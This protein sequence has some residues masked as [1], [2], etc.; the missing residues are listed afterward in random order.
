MSSHTEKYKGNIVQKLL[1][2]GI[3]LVAAYGF[4][5]F[6]IT[7]L[8]SSAII[9]LF[10]PDEV[11]NHHPDPTTKA[12][13]EAEFIMDM[14]GNE[15]RSEEG[16]EG[17][18]TKPAGSW[19]IKAEKLGEEPIEIMPELTFGVFS[20]FFGFIFA[21]IATA[22][23]PAPIGYVSN[24]MERE[25][26]HTIDRIDEQTGDKISREEIER[27]TAANSR[28]DLTPIEKEFGP[29][30]VNEINDVR[31]GNRWKRNKLLVTKGL[32]LYM[33]RHFAERY[34]NNVQGF[35]YGGAAILIVIIGIRGLKFIPPT[36][37]SI[38]L[39]AIALEFTMLLLLATTLFYTEEE[40]RM[41]K[42]IR[43]LEESSEGQKYE[44]IN[45]VRTSQQQQRDLA[46]MVDYIQRQT[47]NLQKMADALTGANREYIIQVAQRAVAEYVTKETSI[48]I[49]EKVIRE[50]IDEAMRQMFGSG[51]Q[52]IDRG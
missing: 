25:I 46:S 22:M 45:L 43:D 34:S 40:Q 20:L 11:K 30:I 2:F 36:Q 12:V 19:V 38:L 44:L 47:E 35:A 10:A 8:F 51:P 24:K 49:T 31:Q 23:L 1:F 37:P 52:Q 9:G 5:K 28:D 7:N 33:T 6:V 3:L 14:T 48:E 41:D 50:R 16:K 21:V 42:L 15:V 26:E 18:Y 29:V 4:Q 39:A 17:G 27:I 32:R 13:V